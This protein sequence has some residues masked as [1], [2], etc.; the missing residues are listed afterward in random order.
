[1][2]VFN[3]FLLLSKLVSKIIFCSKLLS[4]LFRYFKDSST[5]RMQHTSASQNISK[6]TLLLSSKRLHLLNWTVIDHGVKGSPRNNTKKTFFLPTII[7]WSP[8]RRAAGPCEYCDKTRGDH[9]SVCRIMGPNSFALNL[10]T[11]ICFVNCPR[12]AGLFRGGRAW[13]RY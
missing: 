12:R 13:V 3:V 5:P 8:P 10:S 9:D 11:V 1:M 7:F 4:V 2:V 6:K